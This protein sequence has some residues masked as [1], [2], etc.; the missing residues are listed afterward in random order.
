M[1]EW[2]VV[3]YDAVEMLTL[4]VDESTSVCG[5]PANAHFVNAKD[6]TEAVMRTTGRA[7]YY[8]VF[9]MPDV[10]AQRFDVVMVG[11]V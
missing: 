2:I 11:N 1:S 5:S 7:G 8:A 3:E 4:G 9:E 6:K 10:K